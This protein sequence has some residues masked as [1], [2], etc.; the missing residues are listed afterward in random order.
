MGAVIGLAAWLAAGAV[1]MAG[2]TDS[3]PE[4]P[5]ASPAAPAAA[6]GAPAE[7]R[8]DVLVVTFDTARRDHFSCYGHELLTTP[9]V[10]ALAREGVLFSDCQAVVP[11]TGPSHASLFTGLYPQTHGAFRNGVPLRDDEHALAEVLRDAGYRTSAIVAG[12]TLRRKQSGLAQGFERYDDDGMDERYSVV[13]LMRRAEDVTDAALAWVDAAG[14]SGASAD[15]PPYFLFVHYFDPHEPFEAPLEQTP[16][17]N[18]GADG[19]PALERIT[20]QLD[21]YDREIAYADRELGRLLAG[22]GERRLMDDAIVLFTADHGQSFGEHGYGKAEGAHGRRTYQSTLAAPLVVRWTG[23][24]PGGRTID[25]PVSHLDVLPTLTELVG[26]PADV[27]PLGVQGVS[28]ADVLRDTSARPPWGRAE[29]VRYGVAFRGA[30]GNRW[31]I[32]RWMQNRDVDDATPLFACAI[33]G[34]RKVIANPRRPERFEVYDLRADPG[35][36]RPIRG[37]DE[38]WRGTVTKILDWYAS[39]RTELTAVEMDDEQLEA[40]RALGYVGN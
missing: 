21:A 31:N 13:N 26:L 6:D 5:A 22:L 40:L 25:L 37:E 33:M 32:F 2:P 36:L 8:P 9:T 3:P 30:V 24:L 11:L 35:E 4:R 18:P 16:G 39:T 10:D 28:L 27:L 38:R 19:G 1:A 29:R 7:R 17:P 15:R 12:W 34:G 23:R 20:R 14:L